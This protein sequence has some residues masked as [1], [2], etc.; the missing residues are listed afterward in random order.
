M[1]SAARIKN[2]KYKG[3]TSVKRFL[4]GKIVKTKNLFRS[5]YENIGNKLLLKT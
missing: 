5:K 4:R 3:I 2:G 1:L